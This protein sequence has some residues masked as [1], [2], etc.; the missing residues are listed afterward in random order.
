MWKRKKVK[1]IYNCLSKSDKRRTILLEEMSSSLL[2]LI[3]RLL[4]YTDGSYGYI[5]T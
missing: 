4:C 3:N 5:Q 1:Y 2:I